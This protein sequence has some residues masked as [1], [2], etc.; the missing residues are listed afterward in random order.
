MVHFPMPCFYL[1]L[2]LLL[3]DSLSMETIVFELISCRSVVVFAG[4]SWSELISVIFGRLWDSD[5]DKTDNKEFILLVILSSTDHLIH[6]S[7]FDG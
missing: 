2:L 7:S 3:V 1:L 6:E 4:Q 5:S